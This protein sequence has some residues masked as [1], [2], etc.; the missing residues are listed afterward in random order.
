M[1]TLL[2]PVDFTETSVNAVNF[3]AEW[4]KKYDYK[5]IILL[6]TFYDSIFENIIVSAEYSNVNEDYLNLQRKEA[7]EQ[8]H[9]MCKNLAEKAGNGV[10]VMTAV[11]EF[12]LLRGI[13]EIVQNENPDLII[14]G[15][16]NYSYSSGSF[17]AGNLISIAKISPVRVL[18]VPA[19]YTY[20][21]VEEAL[22]PVDY[23]TLKNVDKLNNLGRAFPG[24]KLRLQVL[25]VDAKERYLKAD[26]IFK[27]REN[28]LH[29]YL[30]NFEHQIHYRNDRNVIEGILNFTKEH[31][32]QLIIALPGKHSFLYLLTHSSISE[33]IY[34]NAHQPVLIL[35]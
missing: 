27:E 35:K 16:D 8:L 14:L 12:P 34:R 5:R 3:A 4:C 29:N 9:D 10:K 11:S 33:A 7:V 28:S 25:N 31:P 6:K 17:I 22:V 24:V 23:H 21:D 1:K 20:Q 26:E 15:S 32:T 13:M 2:V 19:D 18:I 30:H